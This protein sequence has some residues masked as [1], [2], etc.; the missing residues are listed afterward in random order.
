MYLKT[1]YYLLTFNIRTIFRISAE[2]GIIRT[3]ILCLIALVFSI[4]FVPEI[5]LDSN[6]SFLIS[7]F[8]LAPTFLSG[9]ENRFLRDL[10]LS[11]FL[12]RL[13]RNLILL[14]PGTIILLSLKHYQSALISIA[15]AITF[16]MGISYK[17]TNSF[18]LTI[19]VWKTKILSWNIL[20]GRNTILIL[21]IYIF[22]FGAF[23]NPAFPLISIFLLHFITLNYIYQNEPVEVMESFQL[24]T[25][26]FLNRISIKSIGYLILLLI[27]P[28]LNLIIW[29]PNLW[30][31]SLLI[32]FFLAIHHL[33][34]LYLKY[35]FYEIGTQSNAGE[36]IQ[37]IMFVFLF[38]PFTF[39]IPFI[40]LY[41]F[42]KKAIT[43][44][45]A[46]LG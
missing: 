23:L 5:I 44:M 37:V 40:N 32:V 19:K 6:L 10:G 43:N 41:R 42:R 36:S 33:L 11:A 21:L 7:L 1:A 8:F 26:E 12:I 45:K 13:I 2:I 34:S 39:F 35:S 4:R 30:W 20:L 38:I 29:N 18:N 3:A 28:S 9:N 31:L 25:V 24:N 15:L 27:I 17:K 16:S 46:Y 22:S 14:I